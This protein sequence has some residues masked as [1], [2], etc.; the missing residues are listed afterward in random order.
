MSAHIVFERLVAPPRSISFNAA[1]LAVRPQRPSETPIPNNKM[2]GSHDASGPQPTR[3]SG[4]MNNISSGSPTATVENTTVTR[5]KGTGRRVITM[6]RG[7]NS[8][9]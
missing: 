9:V 7:M 3:F 5:N 4:G 1:P 2:P 6:F 8:S